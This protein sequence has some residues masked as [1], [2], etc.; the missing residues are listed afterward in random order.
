MAPPDAG[1]NGI[2]PEQPQDPPEASGG[3]TRRGGTHPA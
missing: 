1:E 2:T 3:G